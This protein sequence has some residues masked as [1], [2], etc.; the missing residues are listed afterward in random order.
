MTVYTNPILTSMLDTDAY[1]FYM[2]QAVFHRYKDVSVCAKLI[3]RDDDLLEEYASEIIAQI[4]MMQDLKMNEDECSYIYSLPFFKN[5]YLDWL[6]KFRY[7]SDQVKIY[8]RDGKL[9]IYIRGLWI[10]VILWEVP[11]LAIIS[12]IV[13]RYRS[14]NITSKMAVMQL[15][16]KIQKFYK[17]SKN[18]DISRFKII[19]F[20]TRRRYSYQVQFE[21]VHELKRNFPYFIGSSNYQL[22]R[23]LGLAPIGT[24]AHE[25]FQA[26]QQIC[27]ILANSQI[28]ALQAWLDEYPSHLGIALTDCIN[29]DA[30]LNDFN[31]HFA[32]SYQGLRHDS[33]NPLEWGEKAISHYKNF[34]INPMSKTLIFSD[35]LNFDKALTIY[36]HFCTR[37][38]LI[39]GIGTTLTCDI[40]SV[41][42]LNAVIKLLECKGKPVAKLSD[43]PGKTICY[44]QYFM[45]MLKKAFNLSIDAKI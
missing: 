32:F 40:P 3:C 27:P 39:F 12:E 2:Q 36:R 18:I 13:H 6:R 28:A 9:D 43:S 7:N 19:D 41:K 11:L 24:H 5:D 20:G 16:Y 14:P 31:Y 34:D 42:P 45:Y 17:I 8:K 44:D 38:N 23:S 1:K 29:M 35:S 21:V 10:D 30:F 37:I 25:W 22:S 4:E 33:G 15:K 26:H